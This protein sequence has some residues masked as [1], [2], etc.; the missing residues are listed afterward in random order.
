M[1]DHGFSDLYVL[2]RLTKMVATILE[3][4]DFTQAIVVYS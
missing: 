2:E 4:D 3:F 1:K